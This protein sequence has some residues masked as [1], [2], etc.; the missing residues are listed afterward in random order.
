MPLTVEN[1]TGL[2][3][4]DSYV[5]LVDAAAYHTAFGNTAW[6][7]AASDAIRE[8]AL[9]KA[10]RY[11]DSRYTYR[12]DQRTSTQSLVWPRVGYGTDEVYDNGQWPVSRLHRACCELALLSLSEELY[13]DEDSRPV[14]GE[15][16][17][18]ISVRYGDPRFGGQKRFSLIEDLLRPLL[19]GGGGL[20]SMRLE[21]AS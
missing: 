8:V 1:G 9:R 16:I 18:P 17:G 15:T 10:T 21:R 19:T 12:G 13:V 2:V 5:S 6:A 7:A 4:A 14:L 20:R 11:I 3:D